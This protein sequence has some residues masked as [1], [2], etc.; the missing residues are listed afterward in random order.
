MNKTDVLYIH[1]AVIDSY[2]SS[3][4][5]ETEGQRG[6]KDA[7]LFMSALLEPQQTFDG[8]DPYP[9]VLTKAGAYLRSFALDHAFHNGNKRTALMVMLIFL[10]QN[11]YTCRA[12]QN[13]LFRLARTVVLRRLDPRQIRE[14]FLKKYFKEN[15]TRGAKA[16]TERR[17]SMFGWLFGQHKE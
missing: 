8:V 17:K 1:Y 4:E 15:F 10:E 9:D 12:D 13:K 11:G 14:K 5:D 6:I 7:S 3:Y 2:F 16:Q